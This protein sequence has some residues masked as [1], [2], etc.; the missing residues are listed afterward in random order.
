MYHQ[1]TFLR[2]AVFFKT[3]SNFGSRGAFCDV[4]IIRQDFSMKFFANLTIFSYRANY[5]SWKLG[6]WEQEATSLQ[7]RQVCT[8]VLE[9]GNKIHKKSRKYDPNQ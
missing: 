5:G 9:A 6:S 7:L 3:V 4:R 8:Q 1:E 2:N